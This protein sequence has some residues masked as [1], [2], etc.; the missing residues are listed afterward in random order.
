MV[1]ARSRVETEQKHRSQEARAPAPVS[2]CLA[3]L[4]NVRGPRCVDKTHGKKVKDNKERSRPVDANTLDWLYFVASCP[5]YRL[6]CVVDGQVQPATAICN[7]PFWRP[8]VAMTMIAAM[9]SRL[10]LPLSFLPRKVRVCDRGRRPERSFL[11]LVPSLRVP[12]VDY[13]CPPCFVCSDQQE[14]ANGRTDEQ[15]PFLHFPVA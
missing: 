2:K 7:Y 9:S 11:P 13:A 12:Q 3:V 5:V 1:S 6:E 15:F 10:Q 4:R 14:S 8:K